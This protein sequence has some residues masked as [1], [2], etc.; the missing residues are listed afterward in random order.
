MAGEA[1]G[2]AERITTDPW[3]SGRSER[4]VH[5]SCPSD[6]ICLVHGKF[7]RAEMIGGPDSGEL[8]NL[9]RLERSRAEDDVPLCAKLSRL[10]LHRA[11]DANGSCPLEQDPGNRGVSSNA[12][13]RS[14]SD[15]RQER[16]GGADASA[17]LDR[18][19][20]IIDTFLFNPINIIMLRHVHAD[21]GLN[22]GFAYRASVS[23]TRDV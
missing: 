11:C 10:S 12:Q 15:R 13:V 21:S 2:S 6:V 1:V 4:T 8:E 18:R 23:R 9:R 20:E 3:L 14:T 22:D 19:G 7:E 5:C 16:A 17:I